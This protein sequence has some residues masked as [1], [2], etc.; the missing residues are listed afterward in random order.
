[1]SNILTDPI[2]DEYWGKFWDHLGESHEY[3]EDE[4]YEELDNLLKEG[5]NKMKVV[6]ESE[7]YKQLEESEKKNVKQ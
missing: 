7:A 4:W 6:R 1:M 5:Q 3:T 2:M